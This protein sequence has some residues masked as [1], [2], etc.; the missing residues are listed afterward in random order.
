MV[1]IALEKGMVRM[2]R[3]RGF[4]DGFSEEKSSYYWL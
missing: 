3:E 4:V 2:P 1:F